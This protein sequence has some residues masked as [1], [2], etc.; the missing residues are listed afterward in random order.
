MERGQRTAAGEERQPSERAA[1][2][3]NK[4]FIRKGSEDSSIPGWCP[5]VPAAWGQQVLPVGPA[6]LHDLAVRGAEDGQEDQNPADQEDREEVPVLPVL[7]GEAQQRGAGVGEL[8]EDAG[9]G[10]GGAVVGRGAPAR[11]AGGVAAG[12]HPGCTRGGG[13]PGLAVGARG[14]VGQAPM[15]VGVEGAAALCKGMGLGCGAARS[16]GCCPLLPK[17]VVRGALTLACPLRVP[18]EALVRGGGCEAPGSHVLVCA[19]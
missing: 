19:V 11:V 18:L 6:T 13:S 10:A 14:A 5:S 16:R 3:G 15:L 1:P 9:R 2:K 7:G 4:T 8:M 17:D 12:A